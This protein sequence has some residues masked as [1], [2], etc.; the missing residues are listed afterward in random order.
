MTSVLECSPDLSCVQ[1]ELKVRFT[2]CSFSFRVVLKPSKR[3][4]YFIISLIFLKFQLTA[5]KVRK[6]VHYE[7]LTLKFV[8][9][10]LKC[11]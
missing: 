2:V 4:S 9:E 1:G 11:V 8:N 5:Q 3:S 7:T 6:R 10:I